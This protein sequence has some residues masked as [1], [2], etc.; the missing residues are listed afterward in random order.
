MSRNLTPKKHRP[1]LANS[2]A[3][4]PDGMMPYSTLKRHLATLQLLFIEG[5]DLLFPPLRAARLSER[6]GEERM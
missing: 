6:G 2:G 4:I 1:P 3:E 5:P